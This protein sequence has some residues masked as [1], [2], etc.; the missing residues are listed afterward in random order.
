VAA[1]LKHQIAFL[2]LQGA[3]VIV[4][5][6]DEPELAE[7][8]GLAGVTTYA[9]DIPRSITPWR[10]MRA[11]LRL[12]EFFRD[13]QIQIAHST[14]PKAGLLT[15]IAAFLARVPI[16]LHT[17][18][19]QP[20]VTLRGIKRWLARVSDVLIGKLNTRCY[21][22]SPSQ[23]QFLIT[24]KL[25]PADRLCVIGAGSLAGVD[26]QRFNA[27][28][29]PLV[30]R[31][32]IRTS[33][34]I[35]E[36]VPV[37]LFIGRITVDKGIRELLGAFRTLKARGS[38]AHLVFV[39][40][41]DSGSGVAG[42]L[43]PQDLENIADLHLMGYTDIPEAYMAITDILCLPSYREGFGTVVIEAAAMGVPTV[44]TAIYGLSDAVVQGE[45]GLL[46]P[47]RNADELAAAL[48]KLLSNRPL[49]TKMGA[50]ARRRANDKF[51]AAIFNQLVV[52]EYLSLLKAA[53]IAP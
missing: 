1:Q 30:E 35:P 5:T 22:D 12:Y 20:W 36:F 2:G 8:E 24:E 43:S 10:D 49:R 52:D 19:G 42:T 7:F 31:L 25:L 50:A 3:K 4:V 34:G 44:G 18:T 9:I 33:L 28:R 48:D 11:L 29:F 26:S 47:P 39:G 32:A 6:R 16:R 41:F 45:T 23:R 14:T 51:D 15:A 53:R 40:R 13:Q 17:F 21:A 27:D 46:V 38:D 37:L